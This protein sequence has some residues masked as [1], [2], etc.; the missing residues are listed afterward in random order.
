MAK[1]AIAYM[2]QNGNGFTNDKEPW[3]DECDDDYQKKSIRINSN[4]I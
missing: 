2:D 4:R 1:I 3:I